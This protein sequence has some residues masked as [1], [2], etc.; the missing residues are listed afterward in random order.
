MNVEVLTVGDF[1]AV[2]S[3]GVCG[4]V[5]AINQPDPFFTETSQ[6]V[7][8]QERPEAEPRR[9]RLEPTDYTVID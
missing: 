1:I 7:L 3:L 9:Y 8:L 4:Q 6:T 2:P 5:V